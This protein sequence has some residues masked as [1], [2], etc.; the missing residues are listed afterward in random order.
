MSTYLFSYSY[1]YIYIYI[2]FSICISYIDTILA[3]GRKTTPNSA[4][5]PRRWVKVFFMDFSMVKQVFVV[6]WL[7]KR[8]R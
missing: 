1:V 7:F 3:L 2:R 5:L 4:C 8:G 6:P